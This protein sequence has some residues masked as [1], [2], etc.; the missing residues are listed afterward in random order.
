MGSP[1]GPT[2]ANIFLGFHEQNWLTNCPVEFK[3]RYYARYVDDIFLLFRKSDDLEKF[4]AYMNDR[5]PN[6]HFTSETEDKNT[7]PFLDTNVIRDDDNF[8]T[9]VYRKK[10]FSG[11]Y[12]NYNSFLPEIYKFNF[13]STLLFRAYK[14]A[15]SWSL[16]HEEIEKQK[17]IM[18]RNSY[19]EKVLDSIIKRF[20]F[21]RWSNNKNQ[22]SQQ[23]RK[24]IQLIAPFLGSAS[25]KI[26]KTLKN[27]IER[28]NTD[29]K[30]QI[31]Y[32]A[33]SRLSSLFRFKDQIPS[34]LHSRVVYH[35][36]C[37][38]CNSTYIGKTRR[39]TK[40]RFAEHLGISPL[41]GKRITVHNETHIHTHN[42]ECNCNCRASYKDF[43]ILCKDSSKSDY[44]LRTKESLYIRLQRS[45]IN[46]QKQSIP[47]MLFSD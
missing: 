17:D 29:L 21:K 44:I 5:H 31:I 2:L 6:M 18:I 46:G 26:E 37:S 7:L 34:Y 27:V 25:R 35:Y 13:I 14:I 11:V 3:P 19:P 8:L 1:L 36:K 9:S 12:T 40:T 42:N 20:L 33:A 39:H 47:L 41:T 4:K 30:T 22:H 32:R 16:I 28:N 43:T 38:G 23:T 10:T 45:K 15:S 24:T